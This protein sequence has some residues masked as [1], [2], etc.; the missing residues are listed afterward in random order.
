MF[1]DITDEDEEDEI[2]EVKSR[3]EGREYLLIQT[4]ESA[5]ETPDWR[6]KKPAIGPIQVRI[7]W[8]D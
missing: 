2:D 3:D 5:S 7:L 6:S 1:E 8:H 4:D